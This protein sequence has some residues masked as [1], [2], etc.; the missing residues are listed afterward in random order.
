MLMILTSINKKGGSNCFKETK[1]T[2]KYFIYYLFH[3][4]LNKK[5]VRKKNFEKQFLI[6]KSSIEN[7]MEEIDWFNIEYYFILASGYLIEPIN[8][9]S[10]INYS[11]L[12]V[13]CFY[14]DHYF[15]INLTI[16]CAESICL[17]ISYL[18]F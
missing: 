13:F 10:I 4:F 18:L 7:S 17:F 11:S 3:K 9:Q 8:I 5:F 14:A 16:K 6:R 12:S 15:L 2:K 1:I